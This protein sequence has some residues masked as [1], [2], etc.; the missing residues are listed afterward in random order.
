MKTHAEDEGVM[1][2]R[3]ATVDEA[4]HVVRAPHFPP[5]GSRGMTNTRRAT[6]YGYHF[7]SYYQDAADNILGIIQIE[8]REVLDHL[9]AIATLDG[10]DVLFIDPPDLSMALGHFGEYDHPQFLE[11]LQETINA[12]RK[13]AKRPALS[14]LI[15]MIS[16]SIK[17]GRTHDCRRVG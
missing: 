7:S 13:A 6:G 10:V 4:K 15:P 14:Y 5:K 8:T 16:R 11:A 2:P 9:D 17:T 3:I 1:C 12:A